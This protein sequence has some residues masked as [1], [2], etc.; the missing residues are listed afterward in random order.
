MN[1]NIVAVITDFGTLDGYVG[2][3]KGKILSLNPAAEIV[4]ISH[5]IPPFDIR[6]AAFC[7]YNSY[8]FFPEGTVFVVVVDPGV[9]TERK[10]LVVQ[11]ESYVF[12]GPDNGVFSFILEEHSP[13]IYEI[14]LHRLPGEVSP[15]FH[16]RDVFAPLA[17]WISAGQTVEAY[18]QEV[19]NA[20]SFW[21][22]PEEIAPGEWRLKIIH[23]DH[24][25]NAI[26]NL[27]KRDLEL[28]APFLPEKLE[29]K[30]FIIRRFLTTFGEA[31]KGELCMLWDSS[32]FLQIACN[33]GH[34]ARRLKLRVGDGV[35][36]CAGIKSG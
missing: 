21:E 2:A 15:T 3:M 8:S 31:G 22:R 1:R 7:L 29:G 34:A 27:R 35:R 20:F 10:G 5:E 13:R 30:G 33:Q 6:G 25:G 12:V 17:A 32:G 9:G 4:D 36:L 23:I 28:A 19:R 26:L 14:L 11:T 24:F 16:G 18:L